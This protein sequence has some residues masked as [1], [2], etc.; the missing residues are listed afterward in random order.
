MTNTEQAQRN[1]LVHS[2]AT[3]LLQTGDSVDA[4]EIAQ[5]A[6]LTEQEVERSLQDLSRQGFITIASAGVVATFPLDGSYKSTHNGHGASAAMHRLLSNALQRDTLQAFTFTQPWAS[7]VASSVKRNETR[8][9]SSGYKGPLAIHTAKSFPLSAQERC[10]EEPFRQALLQAGYT[11]TTGKK[12]NAWNLPL[13]QVVAIAWLEDVWQIT[14]QT[15]QHIPPAHSW[16]RAFGNYGPGRFVWAFSAIYRLQTPLP[17]RG[18]L[19][20]WEWQPPDAF[21][22]ETQISLDA[23]RKV[24][25]KK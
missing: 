3:G 10:F 6:G 24:E 12:T 9:W 22:N 1:A 16:E 20:L 13:G 23:Y 25:V 19:G 17:A 15:I 18:S 14:T 4:W 5:E 8:S 21:W 2:A 7:L 11:P